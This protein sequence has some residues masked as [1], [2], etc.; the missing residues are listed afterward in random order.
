MRPRRLR[1]VVILLL[2]ALMAC[3]ALRPLLLG[4]SAEEPPTRLLAWNVYLFLIPLGLGACLLSGARWALM[5][6]VIYATIGLALD[7]STIVQ[8]LTRG[9]GEALTLGLSGLTGLI[10]FAVLVAA[11]HGFLHSQASGPPPGSPPPNLPFRP[12]C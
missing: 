7:V 10:N 1:H 6:A 4:P 2:A 12:S 3:A 8:E 5:G 11:G 9:K